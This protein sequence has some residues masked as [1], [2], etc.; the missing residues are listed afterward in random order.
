MMTYI[1]DFPST[2]SMISEHLMRKLPSVSN[3]QPTNLLVLH[4][5]SLFDTN[6]ALETGGKIFEE[7]N[8]VLKVSGS[9][10]I[11]QLKWF[12]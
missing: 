4:N 10:E 6:I 8:E 5:P 9:T 1:C 3:T 11:P 2:N 12:Q 7:L